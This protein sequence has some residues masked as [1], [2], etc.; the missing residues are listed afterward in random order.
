MLSIMD[1]AALANAGVSLTDNEISRGAELVMAGT[2]IALVAGKPLGVIGA[3][4]LA[5]RLGCSQLA[6]RVSWGAS[7]WSAC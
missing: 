3:T 6:P 5:V 7:V 4:W 2:A 1:L